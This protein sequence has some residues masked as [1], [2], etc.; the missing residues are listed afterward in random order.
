MPKVRGGDA[1]HLALLH[2][3]GADGNVIGAGFSIGKA[4][5][6]FV[7]LLDRRRVQK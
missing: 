5:E 1:L 4:D 6:N 7:A 3:R 2:A